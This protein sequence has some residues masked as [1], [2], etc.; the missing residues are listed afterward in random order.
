MGDTQAT[1]SGV[2]IAF[3]FMFLSASSPCKTLA[4]RRPHSKVFSKYFMVSLVGQA[5]AQL[6][7]LIL[8]YRQAVALTPEDEA[9][10]GWSSSTLPWPA[11]GSAA[12]PATPPW[13]QA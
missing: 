8:C 13:T 4:N 10:E 2:I 1:V 3:L 9:G 11:W 7:F 6:A 5:A 12:H